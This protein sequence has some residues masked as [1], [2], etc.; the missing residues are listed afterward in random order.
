MAQI[1]Q[2]VSCPSCG[3]PVVFIEGKE[4]TVCSSCGHQLFRED[5]NAALK[6]RY[7][8]EKRKIESQNNKNV[9]TTFLKMIGM[10]LLGLIGLIFMASQM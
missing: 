7:D 1:V 8:I 5:T 4:S 2:K 9:I 10:I 6:M 3:A